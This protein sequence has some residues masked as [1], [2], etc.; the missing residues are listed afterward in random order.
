MRPRCLVADDLAQRVKDAS[1]IVEV[2][3]EYLPLQRKGRTYKALC[4][5]HDDHHPSLDVDPARQTFRCW[6]CGKTGDVFTFVMERERVTFPE[7]LELLAHR[8]HIPMERKRGQRSGPSRAQ[9]LDAMKWAAEVYHRH[10]Y[11]PQHDPARQYLEDRNLNPE[12]WE[13]YQIGFASNRWDWLVG[14]AATAQQS[15]ALLV[16]VGLCGRRNDGSLYDRFRDRIIFPIRDGQGR[17]VGLGGRI[18]PG[19][20]PTGE[21]VKYYNSS[22]TPLFKKSQ[23]LYGID[24]A[25]DAAVKVGYLAVVEG[26]T[27]VLMAHQMGVLP[28][29]ATLGTAL[30]EQHLSLLRKYVPRVILVF[31]ADAG[32]RGGVDRALQLFLQHEID[33]S[34]AWLPEGMD[35]CDYLIAQGPQAFQSCL[36]KARDALEYKIDSVLTP[37]RLASV[38]GQRQALEEVLQAIALIPEKTHGSLQ[39]KKELALNRMAQR[40]GVLDEKVLWKRIAELQ[41]RRPVGLNRPANLAAPRRETAAQ[42][43]TRSSKPEPVEDSAAAEGHRKTDRI[44]RELVAVLLGAPRLIVKAK[45]SVQVEEIRHLGVRQVVE[46][47]YNLAAE[48]KEE[49]LIPVLVRERLADRPRVAEAAAKALAEGQAHG[50]HDLWFEQLMAAFQARREK[51][52]S[53]AIRLQLKNVTQEQP[54]PKELLARLQP[55]HN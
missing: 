47:L 44:E 38:D 30:N 33:L 10:L 43:A 42:P 55:K 36:E 17:V 4:P 23:N 35:P 27:D 8:A 52:H 46:I 19:A 9:L 53:R 26:Y 13:Q 51:E 12:T 11:E 32:G 40:F 16:E 54:V 41:R 6:A 1:D 21:E 15:E 14:Q 5:F 50:H 18:L 29:V 28:V 7:A 49:E 22:D 37:E 2:I 31:D 25:K 3:G 48:A 34:I 20:N 39:T 24:R 45:Q